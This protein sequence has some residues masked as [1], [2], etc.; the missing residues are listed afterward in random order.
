[1]VSFHRFLNF[2]RRVVF[3]VFRQHF[4]REDMIAFFQLALHHNALPFTEQIRQNAFV[5]DIH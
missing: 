5:R 1:M 2:W 4:F 3:V